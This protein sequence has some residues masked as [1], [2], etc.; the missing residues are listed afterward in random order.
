MK[1]RQEQE[2]RQNKRPVIFGEVL[3][4]TFPDGSSVLGGAPFNVAWH[5]K[6]FGLDPLFLS[7]VGDD[8]NGRKVRHQMHDWGMDLS[9]LQTD[10][11]HSTGTV[12]IELNNGQPR[13]SIL[14]DRAYDFIAQDE[15]IELLN[16][17]PGA[18]L[19]FGTL[20]SRSD[21]SSSTLSAIRQMGMPSYVNINLRD[22][23]WDEEIV[24]QSIQHSR[25]IKL[26]DD[27]IRLVSE[28][29]DLAKA[30]Q[31]L[32]HDYSLNWII[33]TKGGEGAFIATKDQIINCEPAR[34]EKMVDT[35]GAGDAFSSVTL[36]GILQRWPLQTILQ[37]AV[38]FAAQICMVRGATIRDKV[39]YQNTLESWLKESI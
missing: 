38:D 19:Y 16:K 25:W 4:D 14:P 9:G 8:E 5:L 29:T 33:V 20:I 21:V 10:P 12:N 1:D 30:A 15:C 24:K 27:E 36:Y 6:G 3:F 28:Q 26:N 35:V 13:F 39:F 34:V 22:P 31:A 32:I 23:W 2:D 7:R 37:R 11:Q 18:L 17:Q